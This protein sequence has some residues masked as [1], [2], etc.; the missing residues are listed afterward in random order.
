MPA[1]P[2]SR[3]ES[4]LELDPQPAVVVVGLDPGTAK[5]SVK[6]PPGDNEKPLAPRSVEA[7]GPGPETPGSPPPDSRPLL[8]YGLTNLF[9]ETVGDTGRAAERVRN[10]RSHERAADYPEP[11]WA[12]EAM[13]GQTRFIDRVLE[14][15][16]PEVDGEEETE[17]RD[18]Q[19]QLEG[20]IDSGIDVAASH[21]QHVVDR[22]EQDP[23]IGSGEDLLHHRAIADRDPHIEH[24][25]DE[26][27][28]P[29]G[30]EAGMD[31]TE[32]L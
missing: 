1:N 12:E 19:W 13:A 8:S 11:P 5:T 31:T 22:I 32:Q 20:T 30:A 26:C 25:S 29:G 27:G 2:T 7:A 14:R 15:S 16:P 10:D 24:G 17:D 3:T 23:H 6:G 4:A 18:D 9:V 21:D 28:D